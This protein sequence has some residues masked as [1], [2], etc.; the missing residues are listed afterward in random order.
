MA[1]SK[2]QMRGGPVWPLGFVQCANNG[3]KVCIMVNVDPS[4]LNAP[5][6]PNPPTPSFPSNKSEYTPT[7]KGIGIQ[8]YKPGANNNGMVVNTGNVYLL[9]AA[10]GGTGNRADSGSII[11]VITP[12][13]DFFYPPPN[14][15]LDMFSGYYLYLDV[16]VD[17]EGA[18][19]TGYGGG[20]P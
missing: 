1:L 13:S 5:D 3:T 18:L 4:N 12:G 19:V 20:N 8:G 6:T 14:P 11:K 2:Q 9:S 10:A 15:G 16:D 17:G 7:F